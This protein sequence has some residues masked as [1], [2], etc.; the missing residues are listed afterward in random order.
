M[1]IR[2]LVENQSKLNYQALTTSLIGEFG[3]TDQINWDAVIPA[4]VQ[5]NLFGGETLRLFEEHP[6]FA[7]QKDIR[8]IVLKKGQTSQLLILF[9]CLKDEKLSKSIIEK[10]T[11]KFI[12]GPAA[13]RY[14][15]WF[16]GNPSN[17]EFKVVLSGKEAK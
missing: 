9:A 8:T 4:N 1:S 2:T 15:V 7:N 13:E 16:L 14:V 11:K 5:Q 3:I 12:G 10:V 17:T 6:N